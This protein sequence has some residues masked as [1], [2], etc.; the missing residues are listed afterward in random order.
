V[1]NE[2]SCLESAFDAL[3]SITG[4]TRSQICHNNMRVA[5]SKMKYQFGIHILSL[6][7]EYITSIDSIQ[8]KRVCD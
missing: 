3:K 5:K 4:I 7:L 1:Q 6:Q 2:G 8:V